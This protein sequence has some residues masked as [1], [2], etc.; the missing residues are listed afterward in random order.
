AKADSHRMARASSSSTNMPDP[1]R[2]PRARQRGQE[3][4]ASLQLVTTAL[5]RMWQKTRALPD[6]GRVVG[7]VQQDR[8]AGAEPIQSYG[9]SIGCRGHL[10]V[11]QPRCKSMSRFL[12][13]PQHEFRLPD[14]NLVSRTKVMPD[15]VLPERMAVEQDPT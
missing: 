4:E 11:R 9:P 3:N 14:G 8:A 5:P 12:C 10:A 13:S 1:P 7:A 15:Q 6:G 2:A